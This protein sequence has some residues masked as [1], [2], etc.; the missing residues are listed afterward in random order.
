MSASYTNFSVTGLAT[1][2]QYTSNNFNVYVFTAGSGNVYF[3]STYP[4]GFLLVGGGGG[5]GGCY[6]TN[7]YSGGCGGGGGFIT[8]GITNVL[9]N[10]PYPVTVGTGG[11]GGRPCWESANTVAPGGSNSIFGQYTASGGYG[12][13][14][15]GQT[16]STLVGGAGGIITNITGSNLLTA[17]GNL[18]SFVYNGIGGYG[19]YSNTLPGT[20]G[21]GVPVTSF[22]L[23]FPLIINNTQYSY[24][25]GGGGGGAS[26]GYSVSPPGIGG[27]GGGGAG[28]VSTYTFSLA[29]NGINNTGGGGGGASCT[30]TTPYFASTINNTSN[31]NGGN[32][33]VVLYIPTAPPSPPTA[34]F[35]FSS[36]TT[37]TLSI[38]AP[39]SGVSPTSYIPYING[40]FATGFGTNSTGTYTL[41]NLTPTTSYNNIIT[42]ASTY[43]GLNGSPSAAISGSIATAY[44]TSNIIGNVTLGTANTLPSLVSNYNTGYSAIV[45]SASGTYTFTSPKTTKVGFLLV[46]GGGGST[47][48][49]SSGSSYC[50]SGGGSIAYNTYSNS[51]T[52]LTAGTTYTITVG[53]GGPNGQPGGSSTISG[54][55]ITSIT[56]TGGGSGTST[57][58]GG[59]AVGSVVTNEIRIAGLTG[60]GA[61][62][63]GGDQTTIVSLPDIC[64]SNYYGGGGG[65][66]N[67]NGNWVS[68]I[69]S[70]QIGYSGGQGGGGTGGYYLA[71][72]VAGNGVPNTGGGGGGSA[73]NFPGTGG[74]GGSGVVILYSLAT[75][76]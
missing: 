6:Y 70:Q 36:S 72:S 12:G 27:L 8:T 3:N 66:T 44:T 22:G 28:S 65:A 52:T 10:T 30:S 42:L 32:G 23:P 18:L 62:T 34:T 31:G 17:S 26:V 16:T 53:Y 54:G 63:K 56:T 45:F 41:Y 2:Y 15:G 67:A 1:A 9:T 55:V 76:F 25:G 40:A 39:A 14:S 48:T 73:Y 19:G 37:I 68:A 75:L 5:G 59:G 49:T 60:G 61:W 20:P 58:G 71:N 24:L 13:Q 38:A 74:I 50:G 51:L 69:P 47:L 35:V 46:A 57:A 29:G 64:L 33:V 11:L 7:T 21:N 4:V 43:Y